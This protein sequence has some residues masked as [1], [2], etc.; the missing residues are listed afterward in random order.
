M[1][2]VT[3]AAG[4]IGYH[5]ARRLIERGDDVVGIDNLNDYYDPALKEARLRM[6]EPCER[7]RQASNLETEVI[8]DGSL[9][10][11]SCLPLLKEEEHSWQFDAASN[12]LSETDASGATTSYVPDNLGRVTEV[13]APD[14]VT[15]EPSE[16][17]THAGF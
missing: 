3:G 1:I 9:R 13:H 10:S 15:G 14:P 12:L 4:F 16:T 8:Y 7:F 5:V 17:A 2:L 6:L 11:S